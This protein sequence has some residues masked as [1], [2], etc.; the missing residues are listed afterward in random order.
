MKIGSQIGE[1]RHGVH[2]GTVQIEHDNAWRDAAMVSHFERDPLT[3]LRHWEI[4]FSNE[5][6]EIDVFSD[7]FW[8]LHCAGLAWF[9]FWDSLLDD[10]PAQWTRGD[11]KTSVDLA[12]LKGRLYRG[13]YIHP[14]TVLA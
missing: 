6:K 10:D 13:A 8:A 12:L 14:L 5:N 1:C 9:F 11:L 7:Y 3:R 2:E 4:N